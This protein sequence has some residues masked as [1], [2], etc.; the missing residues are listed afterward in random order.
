[1][2]CTSDDYNKNTTLFN[3]I[4]KRESGA[5][6]LV[7]KIHFVNWWYISLL[8]AFQFSLLFTSLSLCL[9]YVCW[10]WK[11]YCGIKKNWPAN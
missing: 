10:Y 2:A 11:W 6:V 9:G 8:T 1:M 4:E 7:S 3:S 5:V